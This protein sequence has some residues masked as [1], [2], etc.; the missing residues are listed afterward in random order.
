M[1]VQLL[2]QKQNGSAATCAT[3]TL[4]RSRPSPACPLHRVEEVASFFPHF[5]L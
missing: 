2:R 4:R 3:R 1:I 5:R